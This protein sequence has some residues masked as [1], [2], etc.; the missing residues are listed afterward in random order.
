MNPNQIG[1]RFGPHIDPRFISH[2]RS[3]SPMLN[4]IK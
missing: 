3:A 4:V 2:L 1:Y